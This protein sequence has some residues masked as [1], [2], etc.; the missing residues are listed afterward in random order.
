LVERPLLVMEVSLFSET[1]MGLT[2]A[3]A[4]AKVREIVE[5]VRRFE[6][7]FVLLWH[8]SNLVLNGEDYWATYRAIL[9]MKI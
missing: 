9:S 1:Y 2:Q 7:E 6:G 3:E 5:T 8:N 4:L